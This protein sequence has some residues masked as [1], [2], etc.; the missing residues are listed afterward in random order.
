MELTKEKPAVLVVDDDERFRVRLCQALVKRGWE[1]WGAADAQQA[2][3]AAE[4]KSPDLILLDLRMPGDSGLNVIESLRNLDSDTK[5]IMLTGYG[6]IATAL[7]AQKLGA[8]HYLSKPA[9]VDQI[10]T[11]YQNLQQSGVADADPPDTVPTLARVE[12]EHIQ[13]VLADCSGNVSQAARL[14]GIHRRSLQRKLAQ[15]PPNR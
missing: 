15:Y 6:S 10:M 13:R 12:W 9:D 2:L 14:L 11:A 5:I 3:R 4:E 1:V 8:D 7:Q